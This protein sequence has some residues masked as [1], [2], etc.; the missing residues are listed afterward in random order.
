MK[1]LIFGNSHLINYAQKY[2]G[3]AEVI[4]CA[5]NDNQNFLSQT[6]ISYDEAVCNEP[7]VE[8]ENL[9]PVDSKLIKD[10][11]DCEALFLR[12]ADRL[13][14]HGGYQ[15]RKDLYLGYLKT[16]NN[17][18]DDDFDFVIFHNVPHECFD[19]VIY[20]ICKLKQIKTFCFYTLPIRPNKK[21]IYMHMI[22][23]IENPDLEI[24]KTHELLQSSSGSIIK[25]QKKSLNTHSMIEY[26]DECL[27]PL[28]HF[29]QFT[30]SEGKDE[31]Y[32]KSFSYFVKKTI[33]YLQKYGY[34]NTLFKVFTS[35]KNILFFD[36]YFLSHRKYNHIYKEHTT[37]PS[38]ESKYIYFP[39]HYQPEASTSPL[40][41]AFV[42]QWLIIDML[43]NAVDA[44][45]KIYVKDH[46]RQGNILK[47]N[48][49][50]SNILSKENVVLIDYQV[51]SLSLIRNSYAVA[52]AT[53][54]AGLEAIL[55]LKPVLMFGN[56]I[57]QTGPGV[58]QIET[59]LDLQSALQKIIVNT[60]H[61]KDVELFFKALD[62]NVFPGFLSEKDESLSSLNQDQVAKNCIKKVHE[63]I[64]AIL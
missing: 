59:Y 35:F 36:D 45:T 31:G 28:D 57:Y 10:M 4:I 27:L 54:S 64:N 60:N 32:I 37:A 7:K 56:R 14:P 47:T 63:N 39:L 16:W 52:T 58:Y 18:I 41:G 43:S 13:L 33:R 29:S 46:P 9:L 53:G 49:F 21:E 19:Y 48:N 17:I 25:D 3:K 22:T 44:D 26:Y 2:F 61:M 42:D 8:L 50:I 51:N 11:R 15:E 23:D 55:N 20:R 62:L 34:K 12:M 1:Y 30:R 6:F 40:A 38:F 5:D 24:L